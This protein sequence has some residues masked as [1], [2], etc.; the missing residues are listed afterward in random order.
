LRHAKRRKLNVLGRAFQRRLGRIPEIAQ[1]H[2]PLIGPE[3]LAPVFA[4]GRPPAR[5]G[6]EQ[7]TSSSAIRTREAFAVTRDVTKE[8]PIG[9]LALGQTGIA[10]MMW[11]SLS[12]PVLI[13]R[14][15]LML[16]ERVNR[17]SAWD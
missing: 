16:R 13:R 11:S 2:L 4:E 6:C 7:A 14:V 15:V 8:V 10:L 5:H 17:N 1:H 12:G 9:A 3:S